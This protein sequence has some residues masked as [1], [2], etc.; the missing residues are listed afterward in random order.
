MRLR[1]N[2]LFKI[3][4]FVALLAG[5]SFLPALEFLDEETIYHLRPVLRFISVLLALNI[6]LV[7]FNNY[8]RRRKGLSPKQ[9]DAILLGLQNVYYILVVLLSIAA[10][11]TLYGLELKDVFYSLSIIAAAIAI[12][13]KDFLSE[14]I[15]GLIMSFSG[16]LSVG[17]YI[18]IG[19]TKGRVTTLTLTKVVLLNEDD[20]LVHVPNSNVFSGELVNYTQR[21]QRRVSI[22]F[23]VALANIPSVDDFEAALTEALRDYAEMIVPNSH[24]LRVVE[25]HKDSA[26]FKFRYTLHQRSP[27]LERDIR[28][29]TSRTVINYLQVVAQRKESALPVAAA[30]AALAA[31]HSAEA[32]PPERAE[33]EHSS[34][35][36]PLSPRTLPNN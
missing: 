25:L 14:I 21:M 33:I 15:S 36:I 10:G 3:L 9:E 13:T 29:K 12:V 2:L 27:T 6:A 28:R 30:A 23:E 5:A 32:A 1:W 4:L 31:V 19:N 8:Y 35:P 22:E 20:D 11:I 26:E 34:Q 18:S 16:Q 17:D 24:S 7:L